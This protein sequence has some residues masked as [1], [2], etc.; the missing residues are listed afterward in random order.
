MKSQCLNWLEK[1]EGK[2]YMGMLTI[3]SSDLAGKNTAAH[4]LDKPA[5]PGTPATELLPTESH[6][7]VRDGL[8]AIFSWQNTGS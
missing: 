6:Q 2:I 1:G 8:H 7:T 4:M 3:H 5:W